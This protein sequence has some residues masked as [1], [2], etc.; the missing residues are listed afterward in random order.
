MARNIAIFILSLVFTAE[1][2]LL[3]IYWSFSINGANNYPRSDLLW[4]SEQ[5]IDPRSA[6]LPRNNLSLLP[7]SQVKVGETIFRVWLAQTPQSRTLG[8]SNQE[9]IKDEEGMLFVFEEGAIHDFG[10]KGVKFNLDIIWI[11]DNQIVG[12]VQNLPVQT[13]TVQLPASHM[14]AQQAQYALEINGG[15]SQKYGF[16]VGTPVIINFQSEPEREPGYQSILPSQFNLK[17]PFAVQAPYS[18]WYEPY[19]EFCEE[20]TLLMIIKYFEGKT[21]ISNEEI[22]KQLLE[23]MAYEKQKFG[24]YYN[25]SI[26]EIAAFLE[27]FYGF[28]NYEIINNGTLSDIKVSLTNGYPVILPVAGRLFGNPYFHPPGPIYHTIVITGYN[29]ST[30]EFIVNDPGTIRGWGMRYSYAIIEKA[31]H[32]WTGSNETI[33]QGGRNLLVVKGEL[34]Y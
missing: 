29:N 12:I 6:S 11:A 19:E 15:L 33:L 16:K 34:K 28:K 23:M 32:D 24:N 17:V 18:R 22:D 7:Q 21:L 2:Y 3:F 26:R 4:S 8:L 9:K 31:W 30:Q 14:L 10:I 13:D 25:S 27:G 5:K 20:A 1:I